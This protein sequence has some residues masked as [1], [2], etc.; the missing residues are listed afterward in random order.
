MS[1]FYG[2]APLI[3]LFDLRRIHVVSAGH[4]AAIH[5]SL[6]VSKSHSLGLLVIIAAQTECP[7]FIRFVCKRHSA[8]D[9]RRVDWFARLHND[10]DWRVS[11][12]GERVAIQRPCS[13]AISDR[14]I[15]LHF[16]HL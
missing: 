16:T 11:V 15:A 3:G 2:V 12:F 14:Q 13:F 4:C 9:V 5:S 8:D 7:R 10:V 1:S 6:P